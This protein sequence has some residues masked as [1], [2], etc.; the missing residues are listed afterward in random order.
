LASSVLQ[1]L[2]LLAGFLGRLSLD[3]KIMRI[4]QPDFI[5]V[6]LIYINFSN[7]VM[8]FLGFPEF[9]TLLLASVSQGFELITQ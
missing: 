9:V 3:L 6:L 5:F 7:F 1:V 2:T 4:S 8:G